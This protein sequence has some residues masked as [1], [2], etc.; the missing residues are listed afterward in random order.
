[1]ATK[2]GSILGELI[3]YYT[4]IN[5]NTFHIDINHVTQICNSLN[6]AGYSD[7]DWFELGMK[8]NIS[9]PDLKNIEDNYLSVLRC[10]CEC[11]ALWLKQTPASERTMD[12]IGTALRDM[13][14]ITAAEALESM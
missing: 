6:K 3:L 9:Y 4:V 7:S 2:G 5:D 1:M 8:L 13:G 14:N 11:I 10:F 12:T